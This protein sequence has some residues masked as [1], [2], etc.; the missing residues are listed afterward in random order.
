MILSLR[1]IVSFHPRF[2][3]LLHSAML[4][5][6]IFIHVGIKGLKSHCW[7]PLISEVSLQQKT[8]KRLFVVLIIHAKQGTWAFYSVYYKARTSCY[9]IQ[10]L[11]N[12]ALGLDNRVTIYFFHTWRTKKAQKRLLT[13]F[14]EWNCGSKKAV[15]RLFGMDIKHVVQWIWAFYSE[16]YRVGFKTHDRNGRSNDQGVSQWRTQPPPPSLIS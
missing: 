4:L 7:I 1:V 14:D 13:S 15:K 16:Y 8:V 10:S 3:T 2:Q 11:L 12:S 5:F 6:I 9:V